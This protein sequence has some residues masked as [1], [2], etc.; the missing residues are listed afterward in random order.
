MKINKLQDIDLSK[1][2]IA[3]YPSSSME[4]Y[5]HTQDEIMALAEAGIKTD[6]NDLVIALIPKKHKLTEC[7]GDDWGDHNA[8]DNASGFYNYPEGTIFL[9]G[10]LGGELK[11]VNELK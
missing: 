11:L 6:I 2:K 4:S 3:Y 9:Q 5:Q 8:Q 1:Y 7:S 10:R